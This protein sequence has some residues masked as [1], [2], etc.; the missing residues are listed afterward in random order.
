MWN[1]RLNKQ[2]GAK[3]LN[4]DLILAGQAKKGDLNAFRELVEMNKQNVFYLALDLAKNRQDAEDISQE[5]FLKAYRSINKFRGDSKFS[6]WLYRITVNTFLTMNRKKSN[7]IKASDE[8]MDDQLEIIMS[9][10]NPENNIDPES[11]AEAGFIRKFID[12]AV[13]KLSDREKTVFIMRNKNELSFNEIS[14]ILNLNPG[15]VRSMNF[16]ALEKLRK[17]LSFFNTNNG[18]ELSNGRM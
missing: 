12:R 9:K 4:T 7:S 1:P 16:R 6:T 8:D 10:N 17:E 3:L 2:K 13:E 11:F 15:T 5:V 18:L 14:E